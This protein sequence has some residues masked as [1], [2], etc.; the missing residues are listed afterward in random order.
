MI[1]VM[2]AAAFPRFFQGMAVLFGLAAVFAVAGNCPAQVLFRFVDSLFA[3]PVA[4]TVAIMVA[5]LGNGQ[6]AEHQARRENCIN[7]S[8]STDH[9]HLP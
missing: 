9:S 8:F 3:F 2:M 7:N 6:A 5:V 1:S 4:V